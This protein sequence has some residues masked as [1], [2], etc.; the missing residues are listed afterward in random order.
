[1]GQYDPAG[2]EF[3]ADFVPRSSVG[4]RGYGNGS[5]FEIA[6]F[7]LTGCTSCECFYNV[8]R[9]HSTIGYLSPVEFEDRMKLA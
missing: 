8:K 6:T 4:L 3:C 1:M 5:V 2:C 9:R 7:T